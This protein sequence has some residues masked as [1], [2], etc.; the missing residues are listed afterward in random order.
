MQKLIC[1]ALLLFIII[2]LQLQTSGKLWAQ[3]P[4]TSQ[5]D[6]ENS[7]YIISRSIV[8]SA[9]IYTIIDKDI[10]AEKAR[11]KAVNAGRRKILHKGRALILEILHNSGL[12]NG[13]EQLQLPTADELV[14]VEQKEIQSPISSTSGRATA[15]FMTAEICYKLKL[16]LSET[17]SNPALPL[18]VKLWASQNRYYAGEAMKFFFQSNRDCYLT[19]IDQA[20]DG[21]LLQLLPNGFRKDE[22]IHPDKTYQLPDLLA[23]DFYSFN[24][25]APFGTE[26]IIIFAGD[27]P[28]NRKSELAEKEKTELF[29]KLKLPLEDFRKELISIRNTTTT[30]PETNNDTNR[31]QQFF[32]GYLSLETLIK[33]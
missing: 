20:P 24:V 25:S 9:D 15:I 23:G 6:N 29:Q 11:Q 13:E 7:G 22:I 14:I 18:T 21:T 31:S 28:L 3:S 33:K 30:T 32:T 17:L 10:S 2:S 19:L 4:E 12:K 5:V 27:G 8:C 26:K 16:P 1:K